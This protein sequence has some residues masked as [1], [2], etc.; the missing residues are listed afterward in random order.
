VPDQAADFQVR[1]PIDVCADVGRLPLD[2][3]VQRRRILGRLDHLRDGGEHETRCVVERF[4]LQLPDPVHEDVGRAQCRAD[5]PAGGTIALHLDGLAHVADQHRVQPAV[6]SAETS[7]ARGLPKGRFQHVSIQ[8]ESIDN[9][10]N[11][12]VQVAGPQ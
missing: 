9:V 12:A 10:Q 5:Q 11:A 8:P 4:L 7:A 3:R 6:E 2:F 1:K